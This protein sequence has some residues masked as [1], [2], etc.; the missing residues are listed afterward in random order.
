MISDGVTISMRHSRLNAGGT[1]ANFGGMSNRTQSLRGFSVVVTRPAGQSARLRELVEVR[2]GTAVLLPLMTIESVVNPVLPDVDRA[3]ICAF[4]FV[5]VNAVRLGLNVVRPLLPAGGAI[6]GI[7]PATVAALRTAGQ[8]PLAMPDIDASSEGWL[9]T[10]ALSPTTVAGRVVVIVRGRGGRDLLTHTLQTR[11]AD[12]EH[13]EVYQRVP[14]P[15]AVGAT[16]TAADVAQPDVV[17]LTSVEGVEHL[18]HL[19]AAQGMERLLAVPVAALSARI[20]QRAREL[21]YTGR[22]EVADDASDAGLLRAIE[23]LVAGGRAAAGSP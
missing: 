10:P 19:L 12:V 6:I 1:S 18:E 3:R 8:M 20:A 17:V 14:N 2:G 23:R 15:L 7:G 22:M 11:G 5:S 4:I 16:L 13:V 21:G 9:T